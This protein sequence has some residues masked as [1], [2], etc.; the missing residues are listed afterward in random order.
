MLR[1]SSLEHDN[2]HIWIV[3]ELINELLE[4]DDHL[5]IDEVDR[6]IV[7]GDVPQLRLRASNGKSGHDILR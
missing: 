5:G 4:L 1:V 3:L 2:R 7:K 6:R